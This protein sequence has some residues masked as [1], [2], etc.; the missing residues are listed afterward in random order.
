MNAIQKAAEGVSPVEVMLGNMRF[1]TAQTIKMTE[2]LKKLVVS[3]TNEDE[4]KEAFSLLKQML[5]CRENAER[6]AVDAAPY[7]HPRLAN[8]SYKDPSID[9]DELEQE[10]ADAIAAAETYARLIAS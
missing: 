1:W 9:I 4:R 2:D 6:C 8:I 7:C 3:A 5:A 10:P